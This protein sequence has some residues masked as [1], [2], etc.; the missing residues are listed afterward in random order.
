MAEPAR[1]PGAGGAPLL[2]VRD[3]AVSFGR[4]EVRTPAVDGVRLS[5]FPG[6]T[7]AVVGES[8]CGKSVTAMSLLQLIP[9]PPGRFDRGQ[10]LFRPTEGGAEVDLL[11][12]DE[13]RIRQIRGNQ[14][15]MIFQEPMTS[16]NPVYTVGD[17]I[18][19]AVLLHQDAGRAQARGVALQA[20]HDVGIGEPE[21]RLRAYP[22]EFSGGMRQRAMIAMALACRPRLLLADEPTTALDVTIQAQILALLRDLQRQRGMAI[23]LITHALGVVAENADAVCVMYGGRVVEYATV[24]DLFD[25][26]LHPYTRGLLA[27]IPRL[28][29]RRERLITIRQ[30]VDDPA[31]FRRLPGLTP[32]WP[33]HAPSTPPAGQNEYELI[34]AQPGHWVGVWR[35]AEVAAMQVREPELSYRRAVR[36]TEAACAS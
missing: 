7:L 18:I 15:A 17:Q 6:Q 3:L 12:L 28:G 23:M 22:H 1:E 24:F 31:E 27:S 30:I 10:A 26:P 36:R 29:D 21:S 32:W 13:A 20:M 8:G 4:G 5:I 35:T 11:A 16:L 2:R 14:I 19:E 33:R 9:R 34:E 25:R